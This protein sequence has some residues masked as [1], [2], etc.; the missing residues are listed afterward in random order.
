MRFLPAQGEGF[1]G[2]QE[3][4]VSGR[5][6]D[7]TP[8]VSGIRAFFH[9]VCPAYFFDSKRHSSQSVRSDCKGKFMLRRF[10][11]DGACSLLMI[12]TTASYGDT[13][14]TLGVSQQAFI[15]KHCIDCHDSETEKGGF[16]IE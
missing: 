1:H 2:R 6:C 7:V 9:K 16:N 14:L 12:L 15:E 10:L 3:H 8:E 13:S 4:F 5:M 11:T